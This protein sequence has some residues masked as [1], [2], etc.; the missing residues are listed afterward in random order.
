MSDKP[1]KTPP[2][3]RGPKTTSRFAPVAPPMILKRL[4]EG[5]LLGDYHLLLAHDVAANPDIYRFIFASTME[6][7][8][9]IMDNSLIELGHPADDD[10]MMAAYR[11][12]HPDVTVLPD[13]LGEC[14]K[15]IQA[16]EEALLRWKNLGISGFLAVIQGQT[17]QEITRFVNHF[18]TDPNIRMWSVPRVMVKYHGSRK[19]IVDLVRALDDGVRRPIHLLGF[20]DHTQDDIEACKREGVSGIDS[21]VP[22]RMGLAGMAFDS[23]KLDIGPTPPRGNY[24]ECRDINHLVRHNMKVVHEWTRQE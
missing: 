14:D 19:H 7:M 12:I 18:K 15:T 3:W 22:I 9:I 1:D 5:R 16:S 20:S 11:A 6:K 2:Y 23:A 24:W 13:Y 8:F 10:T 17:L 4:K 21:A